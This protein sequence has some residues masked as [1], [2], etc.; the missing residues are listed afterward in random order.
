LFTTSGINSLTARNTGYS[1][2]SN[3]G[4]FGVIGATAIGTGSTGQYT[5]TNIQ[6]FILA[7][8]G[9]NTTIAGSNFRVGSDGYWLVCINC[10]IQYSVSLAASGISSAQLQLQ[11]LPSGVPPAFV[12]INSS[13]TYYGTT[14]NSNINITTGLNMENMCI[15]QL[16]PA[17]VYAPQAVIQFSGTTTD[18]IGQFGITL[19]RLF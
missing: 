11:G 19:F 4:Q 5:F 2:G 17:N 12:V 6:P 9:D 15:L 10:N 3:W 14:I 18:V 1:N 13:R 8:N 7:G 16:S